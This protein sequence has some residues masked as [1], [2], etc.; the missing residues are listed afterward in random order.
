[1]QGFFFEDL[2]IGQSV[3]TTKI[4]GVADI[5]AFAAVS[6]DTNPVHLDEAYALTTPFQ[7]RIAHGMLSGAYISAALG[8]KLP[9]PGAIYLTQSLR[10][11]RPVKIGDPVVTRV[12]VAALD[13][14]RA[15][16]TLTTL[17]LVDGK[18]VVDG[19]AVVMVPRRN[20]PKAG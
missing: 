15:H 12:T 14:R 19:E 3:E 4:V 16:A 9:G 2:T 5:E 1:M 10:F 17:C 11:R 13:E 18:T 8:T 7:G 6:G 20:T